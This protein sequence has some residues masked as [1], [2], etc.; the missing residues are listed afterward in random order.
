MNTRG[1]TLIVVM[2]TLV[3]ISSTALIGMSA[4][5]ELHLTAAFRADWIRGRWAADAC[6]QYGL[7]LL[8][9]R[10]DDGGLA[11]LRSAGRDSIHLDFGEGTSCHMSLGLRER[12][13]DIGL[14]I[15]SLGRVGERVAASI[16]E[17]W[18]ATDTRIAVLRR[19]LR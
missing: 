5:K 6:L 12:D 14:D 11:T 18:I 16:E 7:S 3:A 15:V 13:V 9:A 10:M 8:E 4:V 19:V 17:T 1:V 2:W